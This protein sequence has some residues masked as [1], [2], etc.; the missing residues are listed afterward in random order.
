MRN[1]DFSSWQGLLSTIFGLALVTLIAVGLRLLV[2]QRVQERRE[3]E[4]RQINERLRTLIAAYRTLGG[5]FTGDLAVDPL[6]LRDLQQGP[7]AASSSDRSRR[8]RDAVEAALSDIVLLGTEEQVRLAAI[9]ATELTT[10]RSVHTAELVV[11]LRDFIRH[12]LDLDP[13]PVGL[14]IPSQGPS[15]P[16]AGKGNADRGAEKGSDRSNRNGGGGGG[17]GAALGAGAG[18]G[19]G[20]GAA[21]HGDEGDAEH[22]G[23]P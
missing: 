15:R 10:G 18:V 12:V 23:H 4:N 8:I 21:P 9:A 6:H 1:L 19:I 7:A 2:M 13:V 17:G 20:M 14:A 3:R 11:S 22:L 5:S 16:A